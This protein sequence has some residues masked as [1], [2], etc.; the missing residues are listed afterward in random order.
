MTF[1]E[2]L[3]SLGINI[4]SLYKEGDRSVNLHTQIET[5]NIVFNVNNPNAVYTDP[6]S[7]TPTINTDKLPKALSNQI[8]DAVVEDFQKNPLF[9]A[10][11]S[12]K[13]NQEAPQLL[14][15]QKEFS[16]SQLLQDAKDLMP[17]RDIPILEA[18][19]YIRKLDL[20]GQHDVVR[21]K[22]SAVGTK[23][24]RKGHN[25]INLCRQDYFE[26]A[27]FPALKK[28]K[29]DGKSTGDIY[30]MYEKII[31]S[32]AY[33][34]FVNGHEPYD[35]QLKAAIEKILFVKKYGGT[36]TTI[37]A[38]GTAQVANGKKIVEDIK[39]KFGAKCVDLKYSHDELK[40][41][42]VKV[43]ITSVDLSA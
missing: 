16:S 42:D 1:L 18:A 38:M 22:K 17:A 39:K 30:E 2:Q 11:V 40:M 9:Q 23:Y 35:A 43:R 32:A 15:F 29:E 6:L 20:A 27:I 7:L 37:H 31:E 12:D 3:K 34:V 28:M 25:I 13:A 21:D 4:E 41:L 36:G 14:E 5:V 10:F 26:L 33:V 19:T 24:G 8:L